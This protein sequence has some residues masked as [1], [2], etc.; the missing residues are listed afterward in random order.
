LTLLV[1]V[2]VNNYLHP[3]GFGLIFWFVYSIV[4]I[5]FDRTTSIILNENFIISSCTVAIKKP[6]IYRLYR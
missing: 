4:P 3:V 2:F 1:Y 6:L 5:K